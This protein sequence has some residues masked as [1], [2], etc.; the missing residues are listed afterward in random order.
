MWA[1]SDA[2]VTVS[3]I[4]RFGLSAPGAPALEQFGQ[5]VATMRLIVDYEQLSDYEQ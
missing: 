2:V 3:A 4:A 1:Y 5:R